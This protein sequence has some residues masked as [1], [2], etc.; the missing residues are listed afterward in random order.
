[1]KPNQFVTA[2][3]QEENLKFMRDYIVTTRKECQDLYK[4]LEDNRDK[5]LT[6]YEPLKY[7][8]QYISKYDDLLVVEQYHREITVFYQFCNS[9]KNKMD[10][11]TFTQIVS[12]APKYENIYCVDKAVEYWETC[13]DT[14][15]PVGVNN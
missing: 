4:M 8:S 15:A 11:K 2:A 6:D 12:N 9:V 3:D 7:Y 13:I 5:A 10:E 1:M 14:W